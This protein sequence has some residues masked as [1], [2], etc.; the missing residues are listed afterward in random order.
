MTDE[1]TRKT[2]TTFLD[3]YYDGDAARMEACCDDAIAS[4]TYAPV[5]IF[6]HFGLKQGKE[7][8]RESVRIQNERY[9]SRRYTV[10]FFVTDG[11]QAATLVQARLTKRNDKRVIQLNIGGF[12]TL[13]NGLIVEHKTFFDSLDL[14]Q[15]VIGRDLSKEF[16]TSVRIAMAN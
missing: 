12:Y 15:Q 3:A 2:V 13:R 4:T 16:A 8:I 1:Q 10:E 5:D 7:W 6:P 11:P 14:L 9:S